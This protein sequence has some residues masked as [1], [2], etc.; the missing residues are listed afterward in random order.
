M[1]RPRR[2]PLSA[3]LTQTPRFSASAKRALSYWTHCPKK[4]ASQQGQ[5]HSCQRLLV[6]IW[7]CTAA[8]CD[9]FADP[10]IT[11]NVFPSAMASDSASLDFVYAQFDRTFL[12]A[13]FHA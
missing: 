12:P 4:D 1:A 11:I 8:V 3:Q 7:C 10:A 5:S 6:P 9:S 13:S 2:S